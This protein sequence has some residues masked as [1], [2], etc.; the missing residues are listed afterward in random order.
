MTKKKKGGGGSSSTASKK[1]Q[2]K[3]LK[4]VAGTGQAGDVV[5]VTPAFFNNKLRPTKSAEVI[6]DEEVAR[7]QAQAASLEKEV[8]SK[9]TQLKEKL[10]ELTLTIRR[11]AGPDGQLFGG[12]GPKV[13]IEELRKETNDEFLDRKGVKVLSL[14]DP[15]GKKM[16]GDIKHIGDYGASISLT[17]DIS[18]KFTISVDAES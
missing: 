12:I 5:M 4:H 2:V 16:R 15:D 3:M 1:I 10:S 6:S 14:L 7:E 11:K 13:I 9:A 17:K 18:V 8:N